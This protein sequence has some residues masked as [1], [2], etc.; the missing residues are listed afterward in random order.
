LK[1]AV[2]VTLMTEERLSAYP[3]KTQ[4]SLP[5]ASIRLL[6][7][8]GGMVPHFATHLKTKALERTLRR[9]RY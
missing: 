5:M 3:W 1:I 4:R 9:S 6:R 8:H 7:R 2:F